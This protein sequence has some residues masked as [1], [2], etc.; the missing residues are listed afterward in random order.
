M[1]LKLLLILACC[2][3]YPIFLA[4]AEPPAPVEIE[5]ASGRVAVWPSL[6]IVSS[7]E[8][9]LTPAQAAE[10]A[11][12]GTAM[13]VDGPDRILGRATSPYWALFTL[14]NSGVGARSRLLE[15]QTT[16]QF[17]IRLYRREAMGE[18]Q[19]VQSWNDQA[20]GSIGSG[21]RYPVWPLELEPRQSAEL[22]LRIEGPAV[23]RFP[24]FVTD[25]VSFGEQRWKFQVEFGALLAT[26]LLWLGYFWI[27]YRHLDDRSVFL[28]AF[29]IIANLA[30]V[31]WLSGALSESF[32][33]VP[34]RLLSP[35]GLAG[36]MVTS[37]CGAL[38]AR[39][40]VNSAA[41]APVLDRLLLAIGWLSLLAAPWF[42]LAFPIGARLLAVV[43][44]T[45]TSLLLAAVSILAMRRRV[46]LSGFI[47]TAWLTYLAFGLSNAIARAS[48]NP[49]VWLPNSYG[50]EQAMLVTI[51]FGLAMNQRLMQQREQVAAAAREAEMRNERNAAILRERSL[52]FAATN[53]D[54]R[55][56]LLGANVFADL[57]RSATL[58]EEREAYGRKLAIA[59]SEAD[60]HLVSIQEL[61][62]V[63][64]AVS[65]PSFENVI[66]DDLLG[67]VIEEY[68]IRS[69]YKQVTIRYVPS[70]LAIETHPRYFVRVVRNL[71]SNAVRYTDR[72]DRI[73]VG[74]RRG[75]GLRLVIADTGRGMTEE[76]TRLAFEAFQRFDMD[77]AIAEGFGLG[78]FSA[79]SL[80]KALGL[81][82]KLESREG[83]GTV[84]SLS[85]TP[86]GGSRGA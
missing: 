85:L 41:W 33:A 58:P 78:L 82:V 47:A 29:M 75:G 6:R 80:A 67:A 74:C 72:G 57:L 35:I 54:L 36:F 19:L 27:V 38:H 23:V 25:L 68:R 59:L 62:A 7:P 43:S 52:L 76:Q 21:A 77:P 11:S 84:F 64:D 46:P 2:C 56:P 12:G 37:G 30:A 86:A 83:R 8:R 26:C 81:L 5:T 32:P 13:S 60:E 15:L 50:V 31:S 34:E 9:S 4:H 24:L 55:Q 61:A 22:L 70:Q 18:W 79:R 17:D 14:R 3:G 48:D 10:L 69:E 65:Q 45:A 63:H 49:L 42:P 40:Y 20:S 1:R 71:L 53:H 51:L 16:T 28:F 44:G 73:L 66:V 39:I